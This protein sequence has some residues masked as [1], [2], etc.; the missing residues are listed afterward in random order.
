MVEVEKGRLVSEVAR[1]LGIAFCRETFAGTGWGDTTI[2]IKGGADCV[3]PPGLL[4]RLK[5]ARG[6]K[7]FADRTRILGDCEV[8]TQSGL[9][10]RLGGTRE[11]APPPSPMADPSLIRTPDAAGTA[12]FPY[13][14][15]SAVGKGERPAVARG[16]GAEPAKAK[17]TTKAVAPP[18]PSTDVP[19]TTAP[20]QEPVNEV[21]EPV[22]AASA[23]AEKAARIAE[24]KARQAA[25]KARLAAESA[26]A[27]T[28]PA[29]DSPIAA[30][31]APAAESAPMVVDTAP[32]IAESAPPVAEAGVVAAPSSAA[33][34]AP[35]KPPM[36]PDKAARIAEKKARQAAL[37][38][39]L[40]AP[41]PKPDDPE[42]T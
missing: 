27:E 25:L 7:R 22:K 12:A 1:D 15:P 26:P 9:G 35:A 19:A 40:A 8:Y 32:S 3:S 36:D 41:D 30:E 4:E 24:K 14:H 31:A 23:D 28:P 39:R 37:K 20:V 11:L 18:P 10:S 17:A 38:A 16:A 42:K 13:G 29:A 2:W 34:E 5:G 21:V 33:E 6:W